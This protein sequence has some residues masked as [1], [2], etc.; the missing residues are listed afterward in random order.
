MPNPYLTHKI[1]QITQYHGLSIESMKAAAREQGLQGIRSV[2]L[3]NELAS[4]LTPEET[5]EA[6]T[7]VYAASLAAWNESKTFEAAGLDA[8][9][10]ATGKTRQQLLDELA[11]LPPTNFS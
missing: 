6:G 9:A 5:A 1:A 11:A 8:A 10:A 4:M 2:Q 7:L 3:W